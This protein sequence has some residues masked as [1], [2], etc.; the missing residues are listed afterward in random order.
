[1][2]IAMPTIRNEYRLKDREVV[3]AIMAYR[4]LTDQEIFHAVALYLKQN[5]N[6]WPKRRT[7]VTIISPL[8]QR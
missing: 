5:K 7:T 6:Q 4:R 2:N 8:G 1:M 3:F